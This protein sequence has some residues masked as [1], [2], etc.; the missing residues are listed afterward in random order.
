M[1]SLA[2][3]VRLDPLYAPR[4]VTAA[5]PT[6][7]PDGFGRVLS[8]T[9][10]LADIPDS[11]ALFE[12]L[13][14]V[15]LPLFDAEQSAWLFWD[16]AGQM[17]HLGPLAGAQSDAR[18]IESIWPSATG[19]VHFSAPLILSGPAYQWPIPDRPLKLFLQALHGDSA[20]VAPLWQGPKL[21]GILVVAR[22]V[23]VRAFEPEATRL[24]TVLIA[25]ADVAL[26][27]I[28]RVEAFERYAMRLALAQRM[29]LSIAAN[30]DE[31]AICHTAARV[32]T[33][34]FGYPQCSLYL[35]RGDAL[36]LEAQ[37]GPGLAPPRLALD[38]DIIAFIMRTGRAL[39]LPPGENAHDLPSALPAP[40]IRALMPLRQGQR[41]LGLLQIESPLEGP[42]LEDADLHFLE[43]IAIPLATSLEKARLYD[44]EQRWS[45]KLHAINEL[46][47]RLS[48]ILK[49]DLLLET[50]TQSLTEAFEFDA[51]AVHLA[52]SLPSS[53][54]VCVAWVL[55]HG[56]SLSVSA[57]DAELTPGLAPPPGMSYE[58]VIP[59]RLADRVTGVIDLQ[60]V[61]PREFAADDVALLES[62]SGQVAVAIENA[63]L[64]EH[65]RSNAS[66]LESM[67]AARTRHLST[68]HAVTAA[69]SRRLELINVAEETINEIR[70]LMGLPGAAFFLLP[71]SRD[72]SGELEC[73]ASYGLS[74]AT[75]RAAEAAAIQAALSCEPYWLAP[76]ESDPVLGVPLIA[77][78]GCLGALVVSGR[79]TPDDSDVLI[80]VGREL[81]V[82]VNN[83]QLYAAVQRYAEE[84]KASQDRL[85]ESERMAAMGKLSAAIAHEI[86][87][88]L[89]AIQTHLGLALEEAEASEPVDPDN[90]RIA[91]SEIQRTGQLINQFLDFYRPAIGDAALLDLDIILDEVLRLVDQKLRKANVKV[92]RQRMPDLPQVRAHAGRLKQVFLNLIFNAID[93][94]PGGGQIVVSTATEREH[95]LV[96][97]SDTGHGIAPEVLPRLFQPFFTTKTRGIGMGLYVSQGIIHAY[98]GAMQ[99]TSQPGAGT[100]FTISLPF[101][102]QPLA[103]SDQGSAG[104]AGA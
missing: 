70:R 90:L 66:L 28:Q 42:H 33:R 57:L 67:V 25:Q 54:S 84:L 52:E 56:Q 49:L 2:S 10:A 62:L 69:V 14:E 61:Q 4:R 58:L 98:G 15:A 72:E 37:A 44:Q 29:S 59:I 93:A 19:P 51:V 7:A 71:A 101:C 17:F 43:A 65:I 12:Q 73:I 83:A 97:V 75:A 23:G 16:D 11:P 87:N 22:A 96:R 55:E 82:A 74:N 18:A 35:V 102:N 3:N 100:T 32:L 36:K 94:M 21:I 88:P 85:V 48:A 53:P 104:P 86:N 1:T 41:I 40:S 76:L 13:V 39:F 45:R 60:S 26:R 103:A 38:R 63:R 27:Y 64:Y 24:A 31:S 50:T 68:L 5:L 46:G 9:Q 79:L 6:L 8:A 20:V 80:G 81:G 92:E 30:L 78:D 77:P 91:A 95:V 89:Q 99:V 47:R 34:D